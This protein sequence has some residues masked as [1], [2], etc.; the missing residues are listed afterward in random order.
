MSIIIDSKNINVDDND[1]NDLKSED[2]YEFVFCEDNK[3]KCSLENIFSNKPI[4]VAKSLFIY[5]KETK[6][7]KWKRDE[8]EMEIAPQAGEVFYVKCKDKR[9]VMKI[10]PL[11]SWIPFKSQELLNNFNNEVDFLKKASKVDISPK[12]MKVYVSEEWGV[13]IM[14]DAGM[15]FRTYV[16][17]FLHL[18]EQN[19]EE[20]SAEEQD[21]IKKQIDKKAI[22]LV[23]DFYNLYIKL[24]S[25]GICHNDL[26][27]RN[28]T[29]SDEKNRMYF[30]DYGY[31]T[32]DKDCTADLMDFLDDVSDEGTISKTG[33]ITL[34]RYF[35]ILFLDK[36]EKKL[37]E[38]KDPYY[39]SK[40][41]IL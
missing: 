17:N 25:I 18:Y 39:D 10:V 40:C 3:E 38:N 11:K 34:N 7:C 9:Y 21:Q 26:Y 6:D 41:I 30:I 29:Y 22:E 1:Y 13:I 4:W 19:I 24:H 35:W 36:I 20:K 28:I 16:K 32:N 15:G 8:K 23:D 5:D 14:E 31:A 2:Y 33:R 27:L 12:I 37:K